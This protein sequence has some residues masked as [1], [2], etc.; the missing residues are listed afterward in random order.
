MLE[1]SSQ[2]TGKRKA[3]STTSTALMTAEDLMRLPRGYY[4]AEL[5]DG[6][7]IK[8]SLPGIPH[9][10]IALRLAVPLAQFV[11][12][13]ELGEAFTEIGFKLTSNPDTV[14]GPDVCFISKQRL[15]KLGDVTGYWPGPPDIAVEVLSPGD[16]PAKVNKKIS[17][18]LGF[19]TKQVWIVDPK[20]KT[21][22]VYRSPSDT[23][24][25][26]GSDYL[27]AQD[28]LPGFRISLEWLFGPTPGTVREVN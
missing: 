20:H 21:V 15:E 8:M 13:H 14:L 7:L 27:E 17:Q 10:R 28:L 22:T 19:G 25:F 26:S 12:E 18:W 23:T 1:R 6:E 11:L 3:M 16:R 9:G 2:H 4:R 5:I 24:T